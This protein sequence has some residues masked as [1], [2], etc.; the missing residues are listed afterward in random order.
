MGTTQ[1]ALI[2][3]YRAALDMFAQAI[4]AC[5]DSL[6]LDHAYPNRF[7]HVAYHTLFYTHLYLHPSDTQFR[8]WD[9]HR[10]KSQNLAATEFAPYSKTEIEEYLDLCRRELEERV[11]ALDLEWAS[12]FHWLPFN[13]FEVHLYNIRHLQHHAGQLIDRLRTSG[14][15]GNAWI[16]GL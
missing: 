2:R 12:G 9:R 6:W 16:R 7:W 4:T 1:D 8:P 13:R 11:R 5:P 14:H 3:Q 10:E 15:A